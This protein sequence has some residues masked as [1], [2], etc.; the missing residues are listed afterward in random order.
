MSGLSVV[1]IHTA[2]VNENA[3]AHDPYN[4]ISK[5]CTTVCV[6]RLQAKTLRGKKNLPSCLSEM[7]T[8]IDNG[9]M[10]SCRKTKSVRDDVPSQETCL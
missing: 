3:L 10:Y 5:C 8:S 9:H 4:H 7:P 1:G 6:V 2:W